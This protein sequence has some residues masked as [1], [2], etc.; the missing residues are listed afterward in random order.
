[1][2]EERF[3]LV[4]EISS[5]THAHPI[6]VV[7]CGFYN[8]MA[9]NLINNPNPTEA[10]QKTI[11]TITNH[12]KQAPEKDYLEFFERILNGNIQD[13]EKYQINSGGYA[14]H[15]LEAAL[16]CLI[17]SNNYKETVLKAVNLGRDTD[18][19]ATVAGGLASITYG[20]EN[21]PKEWINQIA[22][23]EEII[24]LAQRY[25]ASLE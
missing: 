11:K 19:T 1:M 3:N 7:A 21:I 2:D 8:E 22:K 14:V 6:S 18:T 9:I 24:N 17:N 25:Q 15:T 20:Y 13:I 16:W 10:Y 12:Y 5:I 4:K 23:K